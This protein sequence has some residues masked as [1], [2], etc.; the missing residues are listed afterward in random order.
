M[1][2]SVYHFVLA[3]FKHFAA[4]LFGGEL[5]RTAV[6]V[7]TGQLDRSLVDQRLVLPPH[8]RVSSEC[9]GGSEV[10]RRDGI[11]A[12]LVGSDLPHHRLGECD[13]GVRSRAEQWCGEGLCAG[14]GGWL[15]V[16]F[17]GVAAA[18]IRAVAKG[19]IM[20]EGKDED[21]VIDTMLHRYPLSD[22]N[23]KQRE[24]DEDVELG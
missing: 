19:G 12:G 10:E 6:C 5:V 7:C 20:K 1:D 15:I 4:S 21:R 14:D 3:R 11:L 24:E 2:A 17:V 9:F 18:M 16:V 8:P 23:E 22:H 13:V